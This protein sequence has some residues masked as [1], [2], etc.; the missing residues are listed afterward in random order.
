MWPAK[1]EL[2]I[3]LAKTLRCLEPA[4]VEK[5]EL[6]LQSRGYNRI[7]I[8]KIK[9]PGWHYEVS[10]EGEYK[11]LKIGSAN[12]YVRNE[13]HYTITYH[14]ENAINFF[15]DHSEFYFNLIGA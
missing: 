12:E 6:S 11:S 4:G 15:K 7:I 9:V 3:Q 2:L 13:Q 1:V 14:I 10:T 8:D 5:A